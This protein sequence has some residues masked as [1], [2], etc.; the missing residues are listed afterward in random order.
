[1]PQLAVLLRLRS[2]AAA[3]ASSPGGRLAVAVAAAA[4]ACSS[5][6]L[7]HTLKRPCGVQCTAAAAAAAAAANTLMAVPH[8]VMM[9]FSALRVTG[10]M[11]DT[12]NLL[13]IH[14]G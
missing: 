7:A 10:S 5:V 1:M 4:A 13:Q 14:M 2:K 6:L 11:F 12:T 9:T 8:Q 3:A